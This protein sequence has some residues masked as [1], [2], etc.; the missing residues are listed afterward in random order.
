MRAEAAEEVTAQRAQAEQELRA[1]IERR[2]REV[3]RLVEAARHERRRAAGES[4]NT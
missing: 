2:H 1:Y 4:D 3:D